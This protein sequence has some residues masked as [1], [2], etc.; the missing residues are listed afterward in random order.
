MLTAW[1]DER[2]KGNLN[3][4]LILLQNNPPVDAPLGTAAL[5]NVPSEQHTST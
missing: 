3:N 5:A 4:I 1:I 2:K